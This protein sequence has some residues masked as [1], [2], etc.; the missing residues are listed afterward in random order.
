MDP[1][2]VAIRRAYATDFPRLIELAGDEIFGFDAQHWQQRLPAPGVF[3][4]LVED[5]EIF[6]FVTIG[7]S[8]LLDSSDG[9]IL[10][11]Y[12]QD[13]HRRDG[14]GKKLLVRGLSVLKRRGFARAV[15]FIADSQSEPA[16]L[17]LTSLGFSAGIGAREINH[18]GES[19]SQIGY[20]LSLDRYF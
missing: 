5:N 14:M 7:R 18:K 16:R 20:G 9:E 2:G 8:V 6:G 11:L 13:S 1:S 3:T 10:G 17:L 15:V 12:L 4:Y 19:L